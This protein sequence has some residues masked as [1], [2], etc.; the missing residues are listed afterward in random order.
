M[1]ARAG[2]AVAA[3]LAGFLFAGSESRQRWTPIV[4]EEIAGEAGIRFVLNNSATPNKHQ[5]ETMPA[6]VGIIDFDNDGFEDVY[7]V[8]GASIPRLAKDAP[9]YWNR[10][11]RNLGNG[12]FRDVTQ[13]AGVAGRGYGMAVAV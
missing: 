4:F 11:Y 7:F 2:L 13:E 10:L 6:G 1:S 8:N 3:V 5:I 9:S 12:S